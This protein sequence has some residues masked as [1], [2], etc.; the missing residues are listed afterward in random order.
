MVNVILVDCRA[1]DTM[2]EI[3]VLAIGGFGI[4]AMLKGLKM[5]GPKE[6]HLGLSWSKEAHSR[7]MQTLIRLLLPLMLIVAVYIFLRGHNLP[8]GGFIAGLIGAVALIVQYMGNGIAWKNR[9]LEFDKHLFSVSG[10][11]SAGRTGLVSIISGSPFLTAAFGHVSLPLVGEFEIASAMA[12]DLG[13][14]LAVVGVTVMI[15]VQLGR[16]TMTVEDS[17]QDITIKEI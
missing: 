6:N 13:V 16:L 7:I 3:T 5:V 4:Y 11:L 17:S 15:L 10:V 14:F 1:F 9:R 12:F 2:G 8:G